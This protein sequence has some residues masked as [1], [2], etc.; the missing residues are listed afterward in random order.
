MDKKP[1]KAFY[2]SP[3]Y[4]VDAKVVKSISE[5]AKRAGY[6]EVYFEFGDKGEHIEFIVK[7]K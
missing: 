3:D 4:M 5:M 1:E 2:W 6:K 7:I